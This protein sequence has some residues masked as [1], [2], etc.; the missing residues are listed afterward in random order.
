MLYDSSGKR[1]CGLYTLTGA[2]SISDSLALSPRLQTDTQTEPVNKD[3]PTVNQDVPLL[4]GTTAKLT[5]PRYNIVRNFRLG[6][7]LRY[8]W[9]HGAVRTSAARTGGFQAIAWSTQSLCY[10]VNFA[11]VGAQRCCVG[12]LGLLPSSPHITQ[13]TR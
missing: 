5:A 12:G 1:A 2:F 9:E 7:P 6:R 11:P 13:H 8:V 4:C 10:D 3:C